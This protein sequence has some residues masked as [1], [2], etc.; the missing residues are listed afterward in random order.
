MLDRAYESAHVDAIT[1]SGMRVPL[2]LLHGP[3]PQWYWL[4]EPVELASSSKIQARLTPLSDYSEEPKLNGQFQ[5]QVALD[6]IPE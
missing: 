1:P 6:Y 2:L 4:E 5:L 3:R